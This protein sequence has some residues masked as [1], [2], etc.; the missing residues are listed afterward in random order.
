[1]SRRVAV[2]GMAIWSPFGRGLDAF[3]EG[4]RGDRAGRTPVRRFD[5]SHWIYRARTAAAI[6]ELDAEGP[7]RADDRV[8]QVMNGVVEDV[9]AASGISLNDISPYD[10]IFPGW[11][12][13]TR[14]ELAPLQTMRRNWWRF[15]DWPK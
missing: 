13:S 9:L 3:W 15:G 6:P 2:T 5:V 4:L 7:E 11:T 12:T 1:M 8:A 10:R 14:M